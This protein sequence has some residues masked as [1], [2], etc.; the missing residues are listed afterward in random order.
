MNDEGARTFRDGSLPDRS[1]IHHVASRSIHAGAD[2]KTSICGRRPARQPAGRCREAN[3]R[4]SH[5]C[6]SP[7][8]KPLEAKNRLSSVGVLG[9]SISVVIEANEL[10]SIEQAD[11]LVSVPLEK[12]TG[13]DYKKG[14][15]IV[16]LGYEAAESKASI[17]SRLS[18]DEATWQAYLGSRNARRRPAR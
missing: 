12:Y 5:H 16:K 8:T 4:R 3:G 11:I 18:V 9:Q 10:R 6:G 17:L 13:M 7:A 14:A 2:N 1:P 15:E